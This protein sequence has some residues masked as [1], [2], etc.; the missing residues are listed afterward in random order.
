MTHFGTARKLTKKQED[1]R[2]NAVAKAMKRNIVLSDVWV[3]TAEDRG[4][5]YKA[6][7]AESINVFNTYWHNMLNK[8]HSI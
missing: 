7:K 3:L 6:I 8:D 4:K 2:A 5:L 1:A